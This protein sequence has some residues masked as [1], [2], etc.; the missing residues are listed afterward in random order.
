LFAAFGIAQPSPY[1]GLV[2]LGLLLAPVELVFSIL[3][4]AWSRRNERQADDFAVATT[5]DGPALARGLRRLSVDGLANLTP[6]PLTVL[7]EYS[8][9]PVLERVRVLDPDA[10]MHAGTQS[11]TGSHG[12]ARQPTPSSTGADV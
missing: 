6:H 10:G 2:L 7:L 9:P 12:E 4:H 11:D 8:H 1:A 5:A 3:L